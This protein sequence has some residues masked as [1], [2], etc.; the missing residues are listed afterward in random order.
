MSHQVGTDSILV[1]VL[2]LRPLTK[3]PRIYQDQ[4]SAITY[5]QTSV[6]EKVFRELSG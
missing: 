6:V 5:T 4:L 1:P 2:G 3:S